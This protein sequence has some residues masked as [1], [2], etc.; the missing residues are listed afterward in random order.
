MVNGAH[1]DVSKQATPLH[2]TGLCGPK[3]QAK[4]DRYES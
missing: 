2:S 3:R 4:F 1:D